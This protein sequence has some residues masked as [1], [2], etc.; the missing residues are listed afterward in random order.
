MNT[1]S[2]DSRCS[3]VTVALAGLVALLLSSCSAPESGGGALGEDEGE[4][5]TSLVLADGYESESLNPV[6]GHGANGSSRF[7]DGLVR[8]DP[9]GGGEV[10]ALEPA[11]AREAPEPDEQATTWTVRLREDVRFHDGSTFGAEDVVA[12]F[13]AILDADVASPLAT[14]F[15]MVERVEAVDEHEVVFHL[16]YPYAPFASTLLLG[17]APSEQVNAGVPVEEW[18]LNTQPVGTGPYRLEDLRGDQMVLSANEDYWDGAPEVDR[19]TLLPVLD[20]NTRAQR[21][22]AGEFDGTTLPPLLANTFEGTEG[23]QVVSNTSADFRSITLPTDHPVTGDPAVRTALNL[24][25]DRE[26]IVSDV[27]GGH[28][29]PAHTP[30]PETFGRYHEGEASFAYDVDQAKEVLAEAGWQPGDDGIRV[31]DGQRAA[32]TVMYFPDD[33]LRRDLASAFA[34]YALELG[35]EVSPEAVARPEFQPRIPQD[36]GVFGGGDN[37]YDPDTQLYSLLHSSYNAEGVGGAFDNPGDYQNETVDD[38]LEVGRTS[39]DDDERIEA[40]RE[41]QRAYVADPSQVMLVFLDHVYVMEE[42]GWDGLEPV[43]EPHSH[44]VS[45]GPWWNLAQWTRGS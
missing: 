16:A 22:T 28:G 45:W 35:I 43:L 8:L 33:T 5:A 18:D 32:F 23:Y 34:S 37:P 39:L 20:D 24:A 41:L 29:Q 6:G 4:G 44:G 21:M 38:A 42:D 1:S 14:T 9:Q 15:D 27:L 19:L 3:V 26:A 36:P 11:L 7:Y 10:P 30:V 31:K 2:V 25:V 40:Y 13:E 17:I 12:T